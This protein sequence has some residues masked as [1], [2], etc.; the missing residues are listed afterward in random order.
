MSSLHELTVARNSNWSIYLDH[1]ASLDKHLVLAVR[2]PKVLALVYSQLKSLFSSINP[3]VKEKIGLFMFEHATQIS[4]ALLLILSQQ[5]S[6]EDKCSV[7][8]LV[9]FLLPDILKLFHLAPT[10]LIDAV[11][12]S[13]DPQI[14]RPPP[15][16]SYLLL[17]LVSLLPA[18][19]GFENQ[20]LFSLNKLINSLRR[21]EASAI[22]DGTTRIYTRLMR[23]S[24]MKI[25][26]GEGGGFY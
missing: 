26:L 21:L 15:D 18:S 22:D 20:I 5:K 12:A 7:V 24:T 14:G 25:I 11:A 2:K 8:Y 4:T 10:P 9:G 13:L 17:S 16:V 3:S 1:L 23:E 19:K 6:H